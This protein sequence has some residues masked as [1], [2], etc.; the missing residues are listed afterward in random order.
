M[1]WEALA[2]MRDAN[3]LVQCITN[4]VSMDFMANTLLAA[5]A[6]PAMAHAID[7]IDEF[8]AIADALCINAGT[9]SPE[10]LASM[11][12]AGARA[13]QL[14]KPWVL[15]PVAAGATS[16]RTSACIELL[17]L[18]PS[19]V[20]G[21]ASEILAL[22][23]ASNLP[24]TK[25][26]DSAHD[27]SQAL[28]AAKSL[29]EKYHCVVAVSGAVDLVTDGTRVVSVSNGV[30]MLQKITASGCSVTALIAAF[31]AV[32]PR[33]QHL[34]ACAFA[35]A[36]F[37]LAGEIGMSKASGPASLR[38]Q[39]IDALHGLDQATVSSGVKISEAS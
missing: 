24:P 27:P 8:V 7:E 25:G 18:G 36:L 20:R 1:A 15:D 30:P 34:E 10:W 28:G 21:N 3:P 11:K 26:V 23:R 9:L 38:L 19:I 32:Y 6:S 12:A 33:E 13:R 31:A 14:N 29:A 2:K 17:A 22:S 39:L 37:G 35:L 16:F 4:F 5:G